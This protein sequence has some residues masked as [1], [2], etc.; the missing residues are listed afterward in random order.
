MKQL[1][2]IEGIGNSVKEDLNDIGIHTIN[3]LANSSKKEL[4]EAGIR[5][6]EV[7][8]QRARRIGV[9]MDSG[10]EVENEYKNLTYV[11]SGINTIDTIL[12]GGFQGGFLVGLSGESQT[13]KTQFAFQM[14]ASAA[15]NHEGKA[16]YVETE[17]NRFHIERVKTLCRKENSH[18]KIY[19]IKAHN[20]DPEVD[21]LDLQRNA[22][23]AIKESFDNVSIVIVDSFV[24]NFRISGAFSGR[25]TLPERN[26]KVA[27]HLEGLQELAN[28]RDCPV[29][30]TLQVMGNPQPYTADHDVWGP[31]LMDHT[32]TYQLKLKFSKGDNR[33]ICLEGHPGLPDKE[34][35]IEIPENAPIRAA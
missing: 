31:V 26:K 34:V 25:E 6:H 27:D 9:S 20:P 32:L 24:A 12:G 5:R 7:I 29:L 1:T 23:Q 19:R 18:E 15:D 17:P 21:N 2:G 30:L 16:I 11:S 10:L 4:E 8:L 28:D 3:Q 13:G 33:K 35:E 22:Y 14:L